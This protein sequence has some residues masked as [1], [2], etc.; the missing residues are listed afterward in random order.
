MHAHTQKHNNTSPSHTQDHRV[1]FA[2][3]TDVCRDKWLVLHRVMGGRCG[4]ILS[5]ALA[6]S[7][8]KEAWGRRM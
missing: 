7:A 5:L 6:L 4:R 3:T 1:R 8:C 2:L